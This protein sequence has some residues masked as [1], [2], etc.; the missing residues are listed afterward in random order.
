[1]HAVESFL[2]LLLFTLNRPQSDRKCAQLPG[3]THRASDCFPGADSPCYIDQE[4]NDDD[5]NTTTT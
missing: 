1:M 2:R 5:R 3:L 4:H